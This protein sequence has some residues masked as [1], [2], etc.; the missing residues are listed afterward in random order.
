MVTINKRECSFEG[1]LD[2][3]EFEDSIYSIIDEN[4]QTILTPKVSITKKDI[5]EIPDLKELQECIGL[6]E[7]IEKRARGLKKYI[8]KK[9]LIELRKDQYVIKDN[10]RHTQYFNKITHNV[11]NPADNYNEEVYLTEEK[12]VESDGLI[13]FYNPSH[14]SWLLH[15]YSD[16]KEQAWGHFENDLWYLMED[17]DVLVEQALAETQPMLYDL[18]IMKIDGLS[19]TEIGIEINKKYGKKYTNEYLSSL[20]RKKIPKLIVEEAERQYLDWYYTIVEKGKWKK[21]SRC[22]QIKLAH[23]FYFSKNKSSR[24]GFYS[25]CKCCRNA[26]T[27]TKKEDSK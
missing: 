22:G 9:W 21:C 13:S 14:I 15:Y 7:E 17:L 25:I 11:L 1:I 24:D 3:L 20:W 10:Y 18:L 27:K 26:K 2:K 5:E 16:L 6:L 12:R 4:K 19:N 23:N 8:L